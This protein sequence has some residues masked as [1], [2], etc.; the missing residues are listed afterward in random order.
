MIECFCIIFYYVYKDT[1]FRWNH[2]MSLPFL[3]VLKIKKL[4]FGMKEPH[5]AI[6]GLFSRGYRQ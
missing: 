3:T 2:Q 5:F 6:F 4:K 1:A